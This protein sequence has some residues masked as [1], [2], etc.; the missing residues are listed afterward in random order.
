MRSFANPRFLPL[1]STQHA[2][3][4]IVALSL[5]F[6]PLIHTRTCSRTHTHALRPLSLYRKRLTHCRFITQV[7]YECVYTHTLI[8]INPLCLNLP[9]Q[10]TAGRAAGARPLAG[11]EGGGWKVGMGGGR[12]ARANG[13]KKQTVPSTDD[14]D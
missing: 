11:G 4:I 2:Y 8:D 10:Q 7:S 6:L 5:T 12:W 9:R 3:T 13:A 1:C 14:G